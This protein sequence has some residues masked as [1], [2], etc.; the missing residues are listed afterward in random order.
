MSHGVSRSSSPWAQAPHSRCEVVSPRP[1]RESVGNWPSQVREPVAE[2]RCPPMDSGVALAGTGWRG[3]QALEHHSPGPGSAWPAQSASPYASPGPG[4][5]HVGSSTTAA[6]GRARR[7]AGS[8]PAHPRYDLRVHPGRGRERQ[9]SDEGHASGCAYQQ[10]RTHR[11]PTAPPERCH[12]TTS[13]RSD[14]PGHSRR[15]PPHHLSH[16][17]L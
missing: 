16:A 5:V 10:N 2:P 15:T 17:C 1:A 12:L 6:V 8:V 13:G 14:P 9:S 4:G 3:P 11:R 7:A